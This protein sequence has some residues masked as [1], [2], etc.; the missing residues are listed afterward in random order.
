MRLPGQPALKVRLEIE[1]VRSAKATG[2]N[3]PVISSTLGA[4]YGPC[5]VI[6][7][8]QCQVAKTRPRPKQL[9]RWHYPPRTTA[10]PGSGSVSAPPRKPVTEVIH[11]SVVSELERYHNELSSVSFFLSA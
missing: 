10:E 4:Y 5:E 9:N 7:A 3:L 1:T 8:F 2:N 11:P 6:I